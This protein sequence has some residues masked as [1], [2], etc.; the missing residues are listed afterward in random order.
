MIDHLET[1]AIRYKKDCLPLL[2]PKRRHRLTE[3]KHQKVQVSEGKSLWNKG[4]HFRADISLWRSVRTRHVII[5]TLSCVLIYR[6]E[7]RCTCGEKCRFRHAEVDWQPSKKSEKSGVKGSVALLKESIQ[8]GCVS[9]FSSEKIYSTKRRK[10][11]IKSHR[12]ILQGHVV[13]DKNS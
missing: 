12:R 5:G 1:D 2:H 11:G 3:R 8:L 10:I 13:P 6:S 9:R 4:P 7:S